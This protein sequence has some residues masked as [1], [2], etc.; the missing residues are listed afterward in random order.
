MNSATGHDKPDI[1]GGLYRCVRCTQ[2]VVVNPDG[3]RRADPPES[4]HAPAARAREEDDRQP[5]RF[6]SPPRD[7]AFN[8]RP[9]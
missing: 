1:C 6:P 7:M 2:L 9:V 4:Q 3:V 8:R 5:A